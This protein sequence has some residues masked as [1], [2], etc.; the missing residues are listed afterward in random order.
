MLLEVVR[1]RG[2][3]PEQP[4]LPLRTY[5]K[6]SFEILEPERVLRELEGVQL[7]LMLPW[8]H[9]PMPLPFTRGGKEGLSHVGTCWASH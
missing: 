4:R 2:L 7:C 6:G 3:G 8:A 5:K 9:E 1:L